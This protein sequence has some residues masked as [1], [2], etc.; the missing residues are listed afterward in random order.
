MILNIF[1]PE[2][3][4]KNLVANSLLNSHCGLSVVSIKKSIKE[5]YNV[6]A[7]Y[8][9]I[10]KILNILKEENIVHKQDDAWQIRKEWIGSV[11]NVLSQYNDKEST[12]IYTKDMKSVSF[13][14]IEKA[15]DFIITNVENDR[16]RHS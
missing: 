5:S 15:L 1:P 4:L 10:N 9:G 3:S 12:P 16:L 2:N 7:T 11:I 8:Q 6:S 14:N 13:P